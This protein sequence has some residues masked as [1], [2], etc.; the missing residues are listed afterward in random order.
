L[1]SKYSEENEKMVEKKSESLAGSEL[2][3]PPTTKPGN[4]PLYDGFR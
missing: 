1:P 4:S 3:S 2:A